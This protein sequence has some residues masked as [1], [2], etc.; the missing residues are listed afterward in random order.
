MCL[1]LKCLLKDF[2]RTESSPR[3]FT[4]CWWC[5]R[6][7]VLRLI[8]PPLQ[9]GFRISAWRTP[10]PP[11][12]RAAGTGSASPS[13][14]SHRCERAGPADTNTRSSCGRRRLSAGPRPCRPP[15]RPGRSSSPSPS[16]GARSSL[17]TPS[18][19]RCRAEEA[20]TKQPAAISQRLCTDSAELNSQLE[21]LVELGRPA[22]V[23]GFCS[24]LALLVCQE[25][26]NQ[27]DFDK[28]PEHA[29]SLPLHVVH[30]NDWWRHTR[31]FGAIQRYCGSIEVQITSDLTPKRHLTSDVDFALLPDHYVNLQ[32]SFSDGLLNPRACRRRTSLSM[33]KLLLL[34]TF[35][36]PHLFANKPV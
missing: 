10:S 36:P 8:C 21:G 35:F 2:L 25:G 32:N 14:P 6:T 12:L 31:M 22:V 17:G 23:L 5:W 26:T 16:P 20:F 3:S 9:D 28:R 30:C 1:C 11:R 33:L 19:G 18:P 7:P 13:C 15:G 27:A 29:R 4:V 24:K 34:V